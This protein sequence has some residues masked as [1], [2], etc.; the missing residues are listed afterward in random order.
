[1]SISKLN[2][3]GGESRMKEYIGK[4]ASGPHLSKNLTE[5]EAEDALELILN[6]D[7]S[8]IRSAVFL[9]ASRMKLET[10]EE[11]IGF[12]RALNKSSVKRKISLDRVLQ[13]AD[14]LTVLKEYL[15]LVFILFLLLQR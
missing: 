3:T 5:S 12:W 10:S 15:I 11:N 13:I 6:G 8:P 2:E 7:V 4:I 1:M 9:I 14:A